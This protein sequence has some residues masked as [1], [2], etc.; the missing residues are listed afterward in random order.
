MTD[1]LAA[2][3]VEAVRRFW[4]TFAGEPVTLERLRS[5]GLDRL[6]DDFYA[7]D[8][9]FDLSAV[10]GWPE[11]TTYEGHDGIRRFY[12][13]WFGTFEEVSF[14]LERLEAVGDDLILSVAI[15]RGRG[16][17]SRTPVEWRNA[18]LA[19][20]RGSK[21]VRVQFFSDPDEA[22]R[23]AEAARASAR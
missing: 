3:Q 7:P 1:T 12:E 23:A 10:A 9:V 13:A 18:Y 8:V 5:G 4:E 17:S 14:E 16:I 15:Q 11:A 22:V 2:Q 21:V 6:I 19:T 20:M